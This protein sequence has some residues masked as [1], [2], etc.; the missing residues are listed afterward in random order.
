MEDYKPYDVPLE[1]LR[2]IGIPKKVFLASLLIGTFLLLAFL[3]TGETGWVGIGYFYVLF[4]I[5]A[6]LLVLTGMVIY[7]Y[8]KHDYKSII[9]RSSAILLVNIPIALVYFWIAM[10]YLRTWS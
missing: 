3:F 6:N 1:V 4:A 7:A 2:T 8:K 5:V 10:G 9:L